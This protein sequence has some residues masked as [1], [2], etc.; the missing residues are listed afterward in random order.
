LE[1]EAEEP[2]ARVEMVV[3]LIC[4]VL[5]GMVMDLVLEV[6]EVLA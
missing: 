2:A 4:P 5:E 6:Q 3:M 1:V